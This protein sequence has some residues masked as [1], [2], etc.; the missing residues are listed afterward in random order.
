[1]SRRRIDRRRLVF[2][3]GFGSVHALNEAAK[4]AA[5]YSQPP[6]TTQLCLLVAVALVSGAVGWA[7]APLFKKKSHW[8]IPVSD[9]SGTVSKN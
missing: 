8:F 1:M 3:A 2:A 5:G 9:E 4:I 7:S 6:T